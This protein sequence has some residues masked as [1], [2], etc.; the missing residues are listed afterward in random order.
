MTASRRSLPLRVSYLYAVRCNM[1][2]LLPH[3]FFGPRSWK[4]KEH[5]Q[6]HIYGSCL[7]LCI[8]LR[9]FTCI[10][11]AIS[12]SSKGVPLYRSTNE[13]FT[14]VC[15]HGRQETYVSILPYRLQCEIY[16]FT[17][18]LFFSCLT[19]IQVDANSTLQLM[20]HSATLLD[21]RSHW[22][23]IPCTLI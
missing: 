14:L 6:E 18:D 9:Y 20:E 12:G 19:L 22:I 1:H 4:E 8:F 7:F 11:A 13:H 23:C 17:C 15:D 16:K 5:I 3:L 2:L 21:I 10:A